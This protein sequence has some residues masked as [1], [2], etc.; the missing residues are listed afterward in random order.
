MRSSFLN[1]S[2]KYNFKRRGLPVSNAFLH[3]EK[4]LTNGVELWMETSET[5]E[6]PCSGV[7]NVSFVQWEGT[8]LHSNNEILLTFFTCYLHMSVS[9]IFI[10]L[11]KSHSSSWKN[12]SE[13]VNKLKKPCGLISEKLDAF[14]RMFQ[15]FFAICLYLENLQTFTKTLSSKQ[16]GDDNFINSCSFKCFTKEVP[17][18]ILIFKSMSCHV[19][20]FNS[21][22]AR[23]MI[24]F[25]W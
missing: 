12:V 3:L 20:R 24:P 8:A 6:T 16:S 4:F 1:G 7:E 23:L 10:N 9:F 5:P 25:W 11:S 18:V 19:I 17:M 13:N 15:A 14:P 22:S 21:G 2:T